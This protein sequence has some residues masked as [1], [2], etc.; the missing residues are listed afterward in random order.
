[1]T[2]AFALIALLGLATVLGVGIIGTRYR[3]PT[4]VLLVLVLG[5][6]F[7]GIALS[8]VL[9]ALRLHGVW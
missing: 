1:M 8:V 6:S 9:T 2:I 7:Y 5:A 3:V 4:W